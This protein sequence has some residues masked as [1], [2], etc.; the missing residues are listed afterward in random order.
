M[1]AGMFHKVNIDDEAAD[2]FTVVAMTMID[3]NSVNKFNDCC[4]HVLGL[5][6]FS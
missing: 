3:R 5:A 2:L 6:Q 4:T 1:K